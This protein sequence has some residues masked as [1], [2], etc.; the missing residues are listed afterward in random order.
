M[1]GL[2]KLGSR[3]NVKVL[4]LKNNNIKKEDKERLRKEIYAANSTITLALDD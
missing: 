4:N 3:P 2:I 1:N